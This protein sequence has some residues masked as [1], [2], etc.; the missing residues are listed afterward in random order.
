MVSFC[1]DNNYWEKAT[2]YRCY[3]PARLRCVYIMGP[4]SII[5]III[6]SVIANKG[7]III[8]NFPY[9]QLWKKEAISSL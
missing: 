4:F 1:K 3:I 6:V 2:Y 8:M 9:T 7:T 5:C